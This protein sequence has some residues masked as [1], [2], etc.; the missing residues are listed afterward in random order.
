MYLKSS[1]RHNPTLQDIAAYYRLVESY[2][3]ETDRVC[4][5]TLLNIG[6]WPDAST[7]QKVKVIDLLNSRYKNEQA[8]F[9][10]R[11]QA[12]LEWVN[13]FWNQ[14]IEKKTIDRK[15][16]EQQHRL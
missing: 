7:A 8:L 3:N 9:E 5:R 2:R 14:M 4:H 6:F 13:R 12:V 15:S 1:F 11:D 16:I 10:E